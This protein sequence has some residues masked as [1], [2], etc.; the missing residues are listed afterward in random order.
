MATEQ[1]AMAVLRASRPTFRNAHDKVAFAVH[2]S[3]LAAGFSLLSVG[4][5]TNS[6]DLSSFVEEVGVDGWNEMEDRY[7]FLYFKEEKGRKMR[8]LVKALV[9]GDKLPIDVVDLEEQKELLHLEINVNDHV[10]EGEAQPKNYGEMYKNF[11]GLVDYVNSAILDKL[12]GANPSGLGNQGIRDVNASSSESHGRPGGSL[13]PEGYDQPGG[14]GFPPTYEG[15][16]YPPIVPPSGYSDMF[17][18]PGAGFYPGRG[19]GGEGSMLIGPSDPRFFP[20]GGRPSVPGIPGGMPGIVPGSRYDPIGPPDV[21]GF[22]PSRFRRPRH[23]GGS[24]H[25][26]LEFFQQGPDFI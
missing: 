3:F 26:D 10:V 23:P 2:S 21:P 12:V 18:G 9:I 7:G 20:S 5:A 22:D 8:V 11:K 16:V 1:G 4:P 6:D 25:P 19:T 17:P 13:Y 15:V 24:T 14:G